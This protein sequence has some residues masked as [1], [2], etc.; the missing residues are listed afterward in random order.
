MIRRES[1]LS[2]ICSM[3]WLIWSIPVAGVAQLAMVWVAA[4]LAG[5]RIRP[6]RPR[7]TPEMKHLVVVGVPAALANGVAQINLVV[8]Q[9]VA[10]K[11]GIMATA[12][13][14]N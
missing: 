8:G 11:Q 2:R 13:Q 6:A 9:L 12:V 14:L 7:W 5:I 1:G 10:A 4:D 3:T